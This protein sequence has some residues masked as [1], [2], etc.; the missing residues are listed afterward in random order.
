[1]RTV[2]DRASELLGVN[3]AKS[4]AKKL[5]QLHE[6]RQI[7]SA[8]KKHLE[9]LAGAGGAAAHR[10]WEP[11]PEQLATLVSIMEHF[12]NSF[13][14]KEDVAKLEGSIPPPAHRQIQ[15]AP[16]IREQSAELIEFPPSKP[17]K[18]SL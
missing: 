10:G 13:I 1:M 17:P 12:V 4:F 8:E 7:S 16:D 6:A 18:T 5:D 11:G 2:F 14:L 9:V 3:P 15:R